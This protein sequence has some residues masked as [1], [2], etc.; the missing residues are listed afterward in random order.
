MSTPPV[1]TISLEEIDK[2]NFLHPFT[3]IASHLETGPKVIV[4]GKGIYITDNHGKKY[5]DGMA[6]LWCVNIG[7]GRDEMVEAMAE[8]SRKLAY[9]HSFVSMSNEPAI[10]LSERLTNL[11]P[12]NLS[13]VFY[14]NSGSDANDTNIKIV[15]Y[16]N[17]VRG[18]ERKKKIISNRFRPKMVFSAPMMRL[19]I[20]Y[21]FKVTAH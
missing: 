1:S 8:Q 7:W 11:V 4:Q 5:L 16:Y 14:G 10:R 19:S 21:S 12:G 6:G 2:E 13:K 9:F 18:R 3:P 17:N 15:W 20:L